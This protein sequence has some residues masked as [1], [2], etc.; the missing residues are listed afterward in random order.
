MVA[1]DF[2]AGDFEVQEVAEDPL[3]VLEERA[4]LQKSSLFPRFHL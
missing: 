4:A 1:E 3:I 2:E